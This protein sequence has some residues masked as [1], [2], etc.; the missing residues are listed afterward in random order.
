MFLDQGP[1]GATEPLDD[2]KG[3]GLKAFQMV[4]SQSLAGAGY[5]HGISQMMSAD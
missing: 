3:R 4:K 1:I 5:H 2:I